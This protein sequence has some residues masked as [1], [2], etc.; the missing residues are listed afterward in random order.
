MNPTAPATTGRLTFRTYRITEPITQILSK[1]DAS[2]K[3]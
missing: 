3:G 2:A 1:I